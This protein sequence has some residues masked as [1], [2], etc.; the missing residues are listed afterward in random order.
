MNN[1]VIQANQSGKKVYLG[2]FKVF[3]S[4]ENIHAYSRGTIKLL[5]GLITLVKENIDFARGSIGFKVTIGNKTI[6]N[7]GDTILKKD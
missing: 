3:E 1:E 2:P 6:V 5:L 4:N 7:L